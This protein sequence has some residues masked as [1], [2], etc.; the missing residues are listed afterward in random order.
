ME[1][2]TLLRGRVPI[3]HMK[4]LQ[5][6]NCP[7][8][9]GI[10]ILYFHFGHD[11]GKK[12]IHVCGAVPEKSIGAAGIELTAVMIH[13]FQILGTGGQKFRILSA[14]PAVFQNNSP[15]GRI[16]KRNY[17]HDGFR[18]VQKLHGGFQFLGCNK[19]SGGVNAAKT[20]EMLPAAFIGQKHFPDDVIG[21]SIIARRLG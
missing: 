8:F 12:I 17:R 3:L 20:L 5:L 2:F 21:G 19:G 16:G 10:N 4:K 18:F 7:V 11:H 1:I 9:L 14:D 15:L 6:G 13:G